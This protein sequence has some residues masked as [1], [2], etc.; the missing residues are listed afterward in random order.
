MSDSFQTIQSIGSKGLLDKLTNFNSYK[1]QNVIQSIGDDSAVVNEIDGTLTLLSSETF[2]EGVDFDPTY[3]P[4]HHLGFKIVSA[5]ISDIYAM[6]GEPETMLINLAAPNRMSVQMVEDL[7]KG[8]YA[9][10]KDYEVEL[11]GGDL[12]A[13]HANLVV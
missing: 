5:A 4:F 11:V 10:G 1:N 12:K 7:Y 9:A 13:N 3:T 8:I 6:N 2:V